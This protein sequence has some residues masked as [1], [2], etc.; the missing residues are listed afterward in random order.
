[1]LYYKQITG[2]CMPVQNISCSINNDY[3]LNPVKVKKNT[4]ETFVPQN[5][6][7]PQIPLN[8]SKSYAIPQLYPEYKV[9]ETFKLPNTGEGKVYQLRNGHKVI[10]LPKKGPTV[11]NTYV[12]AGWNNENADKRECAHLLEH[13]LGSKILTPQNLDTQ[14]IVNNISLYANAA[15]NN[16]YTRYYIKSPIVNN[17]DLESIIKLQYETIRPDE[18]DAQIIEREKN[19]IYQEHQERK[20]D[21]SA[22]RLLYKI[23]INN[24]FNLKDS[25]SFSQNSNSESVLSLTQDDVQ[26]FYKQNYRPDNMITT[27][28]GNVDDDTI[29]IVSKYFNQATNSIIKKSDFEIIQHFNNPIQKTVRI[30]LINPDENCVPYI[31]SINFLG[32][33][34]TNSKIQI[35][36]EF[37]IK[38]LEE[39]LNK[40]FLS[41][42]GVKFG[43]NNLQPDFY[44]LGFE[45]M[46]NSNNIENELK[47]IYSQIYNFTQKELSN[48]EFNK[49]K[50]IIKTSRADL[51]EDTLTLSNVISNEFLYTPRIN[52]EKEMEILETL[53]PRDIKEYASRI[54]D[55]NKA[56]LTV[57]HPQ[58]QNNNISFKGIINIANEINLEEYVLPNNLQVIFD[59]SENSM[60]SAVTFRIASQ[61]RIDSLSNAYS[62]MID[63][64][65]K[66]L[67][68]LCEQNNID[69]N[70]YGNSQYLG[71]TFTGL[72]K[73]VESRLPQ[74]LKNI[75]QHDFKNSEE[76]DK[77]KTERLRYSDS[78]KETLFEKFDKALYKDCAEI[79]QNRDIK[80][81][82]YKDVEN[83]Y[84]NILQNGQAK[85]V[86]TLPKNN[87]NLAKLNLLNILSELPKFQS[88]DYST[89]FNKNKTKSLENTKVF[90]K[91][92]NDRQITVEQTYKI[93]QSGNIKDIA[94]LK[95]LNILIGNGEKSLMHKKLRVEKQL[96][97]SPSSELRDNFC[98]QN[99]NTLTLKTQVNATNKNNLKTVI[100]EYGQFAK[101][102]MTTMI[103]E[104]ELL[105][106]KKY[107]KNSIYSELETTAERNRIISDS[108]NSF[109]GKTYFKEIDKAID[110]ITPQY[111][112]ELAKYYFSQPSLYMISGN[113]E[114]IVANKDYLKT[115]GEIVE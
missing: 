92:N 12:K 54:L 4:F 15:T 19:I 60:K 10:V 98:T 106:T 97:Y 39:K 76:F 29:K 33:K 109:Y 103:S 21:I 108:V 78:F 36:S 35:I 104:E 110:E 64:L 87:I 48:E 59:K 46:I 65:S 55:L 111:L 26:N 61:N 74:L 37:I 5:S 53:T 18:F 82:T 66:E 88:Y 11:I 94:G 113:K 100:E 77:N 38:S 75:F 99:L 30:D 56:S 105:S 32:T 24:L 44:M 2:V 17:N 68:K 67:E 3:Q 73:Q 70:I 22:D 102:L 79:S 96:A 7:Y 8:V 23:A 28:V 41:T 81:V 52:F 112:R 114:A 20:S 93:V 91:S 84:K 58:R 27:I 51:Y 89:I 85:V 101:Y 40:A 90:L 34:N 49:M 86:I 72:P 16:D 9:L 42:K 6:L 13:V 115:L 95:I 69:F 45:I 107:L 14:T 63:D 71:F 31:V 57:L 43:V 25:D 47:K 62:F 1:M 83:C 80:Q 50:G